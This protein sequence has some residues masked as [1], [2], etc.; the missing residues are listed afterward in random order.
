MSNVINITRH[1]L[2][3][4]LVLILILK[5]AAS[6]QQAPSQ[7]KDFTKGA[8]IFPNV[9]TPYKSHDVPEPNLFSSLA[10]AVLL[11]APCGCRRKGAI[12][13]GGSP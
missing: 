4:M 9:L 11:A 8:P 10:L 7:N 3:V 2:A 6:A 13:K 5:G 12:S 1:N